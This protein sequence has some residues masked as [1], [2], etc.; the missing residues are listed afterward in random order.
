MTFDDFASR[1]D[2]VFLEPSGQDRYRPGPVRWL[3]KGLDV[4]LIRIEG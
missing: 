2:N 3:R 4:D 1:S